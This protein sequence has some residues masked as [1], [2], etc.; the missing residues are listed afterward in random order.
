MS[1]YSLAGALD[2]EKGVVTA[3]CYRSSGEE[4]VEFWLGTADETVFITTIQLEVEEA[5]F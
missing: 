4:I 3:T 1:F 5:W 2:L